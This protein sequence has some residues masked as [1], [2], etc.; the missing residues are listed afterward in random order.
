M[1]TDV[2]GRGHVVV[3]DQHAHEDVGMVHVQ[4]LLFGFRVNGYVLFYYF[5]HRNQ[6]G[7]A[8][9]ILSN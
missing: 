2:F 5:L 9:Q 4:G 6:S 7:P 3:G 8:R 1:P